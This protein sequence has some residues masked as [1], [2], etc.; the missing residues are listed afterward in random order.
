MAND[1]PVHIVLGATGGIGSEVSRRL[2][3][4]G[5]RLILGARG[6]ER[7]QK[8]SAE[9]DVEAFPL[10]AVDFEALDGMVDRAV[11]RLGRLDGVVSCVGTVLIK[12][13][14]LTRLEDW[15]DTIARNLT[16]AF[17]KVRSAARAMMDREGG[18]IVLSAA[19]DVRVN[20]VAPS[21]VRTPATERITSRPAGLKASLSMHPLGRVGEPGHVASLIAWLLDPANDWVTGQVVGVDGGLARLKTH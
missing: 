13:A 18:A 10:D 17:A 1:A 14:H 15:E 5:A 16:T 3:E 19:R 12:P 9:L 2:R 7:L 21:L 6:E 11:E 4:S 8:L 20:A